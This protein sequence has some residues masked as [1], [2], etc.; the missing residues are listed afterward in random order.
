MITRIKYI[1]FGF[2]IMSTQ[3]DAQSDT[4]DADPSLLQ[5]SGVVL[6]A[7]SLKPLPYCAIVI[8]NKH[9]GVLTDF[10]G[11]FSLVVHKCDTL[12][13][14]FLGYNDKQYIIPDTLTEK[15][16]SIIQLMVEDLIY[17]DETV[18]YPWNTKEQFKEAF[19]K[20][21]IPADDLERA[22]RN[23]ELQR[24][25]DLG[26][27]VDIDGSILADNYIRNYADQFYYYGQL[28]PNNFLNPFAWSKFFEAWQ[29]GEFRK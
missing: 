23:L 13:F 15:R 7:D 19:I 9:I 5:F 4:L 14:Q 21:Y 6:T 26:R 11:F 24:L 12:Q 25:K 1:L 17:L 16:Y 22:K 27:K 20:S 18:I 8:K 10:Q 3:L 29:N 2:L 28:P